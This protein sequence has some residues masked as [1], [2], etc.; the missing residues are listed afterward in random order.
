MDYKENR[1]LGLHLKYLIVREEVE[2]IDEFFDLTVRHLFTDSRVDPERL[3]KMIKKSKKCSIS[4]KVE[5]MYEL[6]KLEHSTKDELL[7][8]RTYYKEKTEELL[9]LVEKYANMVDRLTESNNVKDKCISCIGAQYN[10]LQSEKEHLE[11]EKD[12]IEIQYKEKCKQP[13]DIH[14]VNFDLV[15]SKLLSNKNNGGRTILPK[16]GTQ[17]EFRSLIQ[18]VDPDKLLQV[19]HQHIDGKGGK[20]VG[21]VIGAAFHKYHY[22]TRYPTE[23]E[24]AQE[25][26]NVTTQ[27]RAI[28]NA[29]KAPTTN[30]KDAFSSDIN[31]IELKLPE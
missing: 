23:A 18:N 7:K 12:F 14:I 9:D 29:F 24:F 13:Q 15:S 21:I 17:K 6:V 20:D 5:I 31:S 4:T 27:W 10:Q 26:T 2:K 3:E 1:D 8:E 16:N 22:L 19:L 11:R 25:F 28:Q 30:W